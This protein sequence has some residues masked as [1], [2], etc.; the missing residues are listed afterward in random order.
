ML[1]SFNTKKQ[2]TRVTLSQDIHQWFRAVLVASLQEGAGWL[3]LDGT[4]H[5]NLYDS[6]V[7]WSTDQRSRFRVIWRCVKKINIKLH[8]LYFTRISIF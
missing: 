4:E 5:A 7:P 8:E 1:E 6:G 2:G 3:R